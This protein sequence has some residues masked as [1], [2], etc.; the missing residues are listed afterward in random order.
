MDDFCEELHLMSVDKRVFVYIDSVPV[1]CLLAFDKRT[2]T[3]GMSFV[4]DLWMGLYG[5]RM[6]G[7]M[8][9]RT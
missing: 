5:L 3:A 4:M 7:W 8:I 6:D 9:F 2:V 1:F